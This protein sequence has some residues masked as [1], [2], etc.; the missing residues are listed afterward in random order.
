MR[1][2]YIARLMD[3]DQQ[4]IDSAI[5]KL[6]S[7]HE[8]GLGIVEIVG[9]G[10]AAIPALRALLFAKEP[11]G[12]PEIRCRAIDALSAL[13]AHDLLIEYLSI[14]HDAAD[15]VERLGD[16]VVVGYAAWAAARTRE[17][18]VFDVLKR[19]A[20]RPALSGVIGA[21]GSFGR[22]EAIPLLVAALEED[23]SRNVAQFMLRRIGHPARAALIR[24]AFE[25]RPSAGDESE[26]SRRRRRSSLSLLLDIRLKPETVPQL[27]ELISDDDDRIALL[28]CKLCLAQTSADCRN[29][30]VERLARMLLHADWKLRSEIDSCLA[31]VGSVRGMRDA[32]GM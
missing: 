5:N 10:S 17:Q 28:A 12:L 20:E 29:E 15:P 21:L 16:D 19:L 32:T 27:R 23:V 7:L 26:S 14:A 31:S 30:I 13:K 11:S 18:R 1:P 25:C 4:K 9:C 24:S 2:A 22:P 3:A 6:K 8:S